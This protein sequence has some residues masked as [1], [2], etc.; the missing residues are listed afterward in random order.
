M[1]LKTTL[2]GIST[3]VNSIKYDNWIN[4][5]GLIAFLRV[6]RTRIRSEI[7]SDFENDVQLTLRIIYVKFPFFMA[8][9][10]FLFTKSIMIQLQ[11]LKVLI[12]FEGLI[13]P[14]YS[15]CLISDLYF[16]WKCTTR[17][18]TKPLKRQICPPL[19]LK[20]LKKFGFGPNFLFILHSKD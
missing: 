9:E 18:V 4:F 12:L 5:L 15:V 20:T 8:M 7:S 19:L 2:P 6:E 16:D 10:F 1:C 3:V 17:Y 11:I 14:S 13:W